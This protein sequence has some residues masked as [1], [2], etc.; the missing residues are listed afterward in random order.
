MTYWL[1][2]SEPDAFSVDDLAARPK[3]TDPGDLF[4]EILLLIQ[5]VGER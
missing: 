3:K 5:T 1:M 2:K 4:A